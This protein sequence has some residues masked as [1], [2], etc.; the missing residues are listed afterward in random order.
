MQEL[1]VLV[2]TGTEQCAVD[3][4]RA[5]SAYYPLSGYAKG[6]KGVAIC[7]VGAARG[8]EFGNFACLL[9]GILCR[10]LATIGC[11]TRGCR[12]HWR[13][14][15]ADAKRWLFAFGGVRE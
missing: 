13:Y 11:L 5:S 15:F 6:I 4:A 14:C 10:G 7:V 3:S 9:I 12:H 8:A 1:G 2:G